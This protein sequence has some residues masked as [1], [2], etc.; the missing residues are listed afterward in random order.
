MTA[1]SSAPP[2]F[3]VGDRVR[4]DARAAIGHCRTPSFIRGRTGVVAFVHGAFRDPER[5]AYHRPGLPALVLYKVRFKQAEIWPDY[6]GSKSDQLEV[7]VYDNW[8][9]PGDG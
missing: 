2:R 5:L 8:L 7:D 3:K 9:A 6:A 4:V 1:Q